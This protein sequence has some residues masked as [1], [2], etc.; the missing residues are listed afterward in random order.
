MGLLR[1]YYIRFAQFLNCQLVGAD[2]SVRISPGETEL[3]QVP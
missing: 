2:T 1:N 3:T